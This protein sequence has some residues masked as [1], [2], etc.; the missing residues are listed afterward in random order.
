M[1][2]RKRNKIAAFALAAALIAC[3][4]AFAEPLKV[5]NNFQKPPVAALKA[6]KAAVGRPFSSGWVFIDGKYIPPPYKVERYGTVL[7]INGNQVTG[8][9]IPWNEFVKTQDGVK[10]TKTESAPDTL[11]DA[12]PAASEPEEDLADDDSW[13]S[14]LDDLFDD[15]PA[16][17]KS[18]PKKSSYK[19]RPK[20][21][22]VQV[23]YTLEGDF[24]PNEKSAALLKRINDVRTKLDQHLRTGGFCA[25]SSRYSATRID[26][27]VA[28]EIMKALPDMMRTSPNSAAL[29]QAVR[30]SGY[31]YFS[32]A[33]IEDLFRNR[34]DYIPLEKRNKQSAVGF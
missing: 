9:V 24:V 10:V 21:P 17:K 13:D 1:E 4:G 25:F 11:G 7:R 8:E 34:V 12:A 33:F 20:K 14:S 6:L 3:L 22:T 29:G 26:G 30:S 28:K 18:T 16:A 5:K 31:N 19:P 15:E 27:R 2:K 32:N 23:T